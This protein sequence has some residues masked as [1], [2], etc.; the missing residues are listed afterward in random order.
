MEQFILGIKNQIYDNFLLCKNYLSSF[1]LK[2]LGASILAFY[3]FFTRR[4]ELKKTFSFTVT[5]IVFFFILVRVETL[6]QQTFGIE[7]SNIG[8]GVARIIFLIVMVV[9]YVYH[10]AIKD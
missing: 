2:I 7:G 8:S 5:M 4:W 10:V 1:D 3:I 6:L 9:V